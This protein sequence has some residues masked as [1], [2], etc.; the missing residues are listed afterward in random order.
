MHPDNGAIYQHVTT[1]GGQWVGNEI[2][3]P[4]HFT[5]YPYT[6]GCRYSDATMTFVTGS[7]SWN[8]GYIAR[9]TNRVLGWGT[10]GSVVI[11]TSN[12]RMEIVASVDY[13]MSGQVVE[14]IG[15]SSG[16]TYG[17]VDQT[18]Y[19][20]V[21][22]DGLVRICS[23]DARYYARGGDSGAPVFSWGGGNTVT[24]H[25]IHWGSNEG[26]QRGVYS[27]LGGL[28]L[29]LGTFT[30][31]ALPPPLPTANISGPNEVKPE[32]LCQWDGSASGGTPPYSYSWSGILSGSGSSILGSPSSS[33]VLKLKVTDAASQQDTHNRYVEVTSSAPGCIGG[34][35]GPGGPG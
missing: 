8:M 10:D 22:T 19:L 12:P 3:D 1:G 25:G 27:P 32:S 11:S 23:Y 16:W 26:R 14:K 2:H 24:L 35:G 21:G 20:G 4:N 29:D 15:R 33:G 6:H 13:T 18:C 9:T 5:C 34:P 7:T 31:G 30:F 17:E 28:R